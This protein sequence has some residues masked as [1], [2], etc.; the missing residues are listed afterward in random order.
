[1]GSPAPDA[2]R[3]MSPTI[4]R[5]SRRLR[6]RS[7]HRR[8]WTTALGPYAPDHLPLAAST[9]V[10]TTALILRAPD[11][12][13]LAP[14]AATAT[15]ALVLANPTKLALAA[16]TVQTTTALVLRRRI[17]WPLAASAATSTTALVAQR[18]GS[19]SA[20]S[21]LRRHHHDSAGAH[22]TGCRPKPVS[23]ASAR[24]SAIVHRACPGESDE[25]GPRPVGAS[26]RPR[27]S[28]FAPPTTFN[29]PR[30]L[31]SPQRRC[32]CRTRRSSRSLLRPRPR[33]PRSSSPRRWSP[34]TPSCRCRV[35]PRGRRRRWS[36]RARPPA[37]G[38]KRGDRDHGA[39]PPGPEPSGPRTVGRERNHRPH[40]SGARPPS[41][42][43]SAATSTTS[44]V[45]TVP[46]VAFLVLETAA[47]TVDHGAGVTGAEPPAAGGL[48]RD[49][50]HRAHPLDSVAQAA[51]AAT[52]FDVEH[53]GAF[54]S[55]AGRIW[56][57]RLDRDGH[58]CARRSTPPPRPHRRWMFRLPSRPR[59]SSL[60]P[61]PSLAA[62]NPSDGSL[63][64]SPRHARRVESLGPDTDTTWDQAIGEEWNVE[65]DDE[66]IRPPTTLGSSRQKVSG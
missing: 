5:S 16:S 22:R 49:R 63:D 42:L 31:P 1:M 66:W 26:R 19:S 59:H 61:P 21:R 23:P 60:S 40:R 36:S 18:S 38:R 52:R 25:A 54:G 24:R 43:L 17:T 30:R 12:L 62:L 64:H 10:S 35:P 15:T 2:R 7:T 57:R 34:R 51:T 28:S 37:T 11:H 50:D 8:R 9:L 39:R 56:A 29:L 13:Q 27:R 32:R 65:G 3:G 44:I 14:S 58:H 46:G 33:P 45:L 55:R 20:R 48:D 41:A 4:P 53:H 6:Y 47:A